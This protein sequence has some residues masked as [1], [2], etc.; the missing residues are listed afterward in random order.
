MFPVYQWVHKWH[1]EFSEPISLA[2]EYYH[3]LETFLCNMP[4]TFLGLI[5]LDSKVH[6]CTFMI[7]GALRI[8]ETHE[9]HSG[10][11]FPWSAYKLLPFS[12]DAIYHDFHHST[13]IVNYS[14]L[15]SI[16]DSVFN[17]NKEYYAKA[18]DA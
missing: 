1:H 14:S 18:I 9:G 7:W 13:N 11:E 3:P 8:L 12:T 16:W 5:I 15:M 6:V 2:A 4:A 10:Y 17:S